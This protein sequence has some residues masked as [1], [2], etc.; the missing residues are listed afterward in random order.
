MWY[1][2]IFSE[3]L[4]IRLIDSCRPLAIKRNTPSGRFFSYYCFSLSAC[5]FCYSSSLSVRRFLLHHLLLILL[6]QWERPSLNQNL[7]H[8]SQ[9]LYSP[10]AATLGRMGSHHE[11]RPGSLFLWFCKIPNQYENFIRTFQ[12]VAQRGH[13]CDN[14][15]VYGS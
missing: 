2:F 11:W 15:G 13:L 7:Q 14:H 4:P 10:M 8:Q 1:V 3:I 6:A 12:N 9:I 5:L